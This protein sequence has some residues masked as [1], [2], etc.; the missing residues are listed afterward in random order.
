M[1]R[2]DLA[3]FIESK[4]NSLE[5]KLI[6]RKARDGKSRIWRNIELE[7]SFL[8][9]EL[10]NAKDGPGSSCLSICKKYNLGIFIDEWKS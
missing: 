1:D 5:H 8:R 4:I 9:E 6:H 3:N 7:L 10:K 2:N